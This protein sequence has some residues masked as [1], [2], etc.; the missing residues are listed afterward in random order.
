MG[1]IRGAAFP[2]VFAAA[3]LYADWWQ[4]G[5]ADPAILPLGDA[6][7]AAADAVRAVKTKVDDYFARC[8]LAAFDGRAL[9]ALNR[10]EKDYLAFTAKDLTITQDEIAAL[11]QRNAGAL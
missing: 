9:Q 10:E 5:E 8:R 1:G 4:E 11:R 6:T 2:S 7:L 3:R